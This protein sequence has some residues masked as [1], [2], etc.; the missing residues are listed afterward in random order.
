M[1]TYH[2]STGA[3][4]HD[5]VPHAVGYSGFG[6]GKNN[7]DMQEVHDFG[8]LPLGQFRIELIEGDY[9]GKK[10]PVMRLIPKAGT[11]TFG[12]AGFLIHGD[13]VSAPGTA[14]HG[15]IIEGHAERVAIAESGDL[16]FECEGPLLTPR[17]GGD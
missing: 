12:R 5:G 9:E 7:P 8:P 4:E 13:S 2:Q 15:C 16:D 3:L 17:A 14:S 1:W 10:A 11:N 6:E